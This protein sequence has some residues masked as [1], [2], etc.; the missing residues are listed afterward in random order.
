M[1]RVVVVAAVVDFLTGFCFFLLVEISADTAEGYID[2]I[3]NGGS[4]KTGQ[5]GADGK[6]GADSLN[7]V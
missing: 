5:N 7:K 6:K 2:I 3:T 1:D 4:G